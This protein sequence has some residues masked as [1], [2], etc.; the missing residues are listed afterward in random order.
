VDSGG[1]PSDLRLTRN[2]AVDLGSRCSLM[3]NFVPL[4]DVYSS[5]WSRLRL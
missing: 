2:G 5:P 4:L 1:L 3:W